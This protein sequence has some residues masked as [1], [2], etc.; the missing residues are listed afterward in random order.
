MIYSPVLPSSSGTGLDDGVC[1]GVEPGEALVA[2]SIPCV[3][4]APVPAS[5]ASMGR[6]SEVRQCGGHVLAKQGRL[7]RVM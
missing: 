2:G 1:A 7:Q 4:T 6:P 5:S 3:A